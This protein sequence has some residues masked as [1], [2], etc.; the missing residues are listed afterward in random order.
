MRLLDI[1][2]WTD[3]RLEQV[4]NY[5]LALDENYKGDRLVSVG[6]SPAWILYALE[7][8]RTARAEEANISYI[9]FSGHFMQSNY[10]RENP[11]F[12]LTDNQPA[13]DHLNAYFNLLAQ[14]ELSPQ[15]IA[16]RFN[17]Q[18][19]RTI[20]I[21]YSLYGEG[22]ASFLH[23]YIEAFADAGVKT[24]DPALAKA[25]AFHIATSSYSTLDFDDKVWIED[26]K[27]EFIPINI[28]QDYRKNYPTFPDFICG[29]RGEEE[30]HIGCNRLVPSYDISSKG[31][32]KILPTNN[33]ARQN[34]I[35]TKIKDKVRS[36]LQQ[37]KAPAQPKASL[38]KPA[39]RL[40]I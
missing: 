14:E 15:H 22:F 32:N 19:Q 20:F 9:P 37:Q 1:S 24:S 28:A 13:S 10:L 4:V 6:Q 16:S 23:V 36:M 38:A 3:E 11:S 40:A 30:G 34:M 27:G 33:E 8:I 18:A 25:S 29:I 17:E 21:D 5:A 2:E 35:K 12:E 26:A 39:Q 7:Q 31:K